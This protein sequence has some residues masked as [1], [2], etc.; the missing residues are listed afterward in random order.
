MAVLTY[1]QMEG[2][3]AKAGFPA[4]VVPIVAAIGE[5]ESGGN[6]DAVNPDDN[7]GTQSSYGW[8]QISTGT[9]TPPSPNWADPATNAALGYQ[10]Y[11]DAGNTF[12]PWGTY[13]SGA[14]KAYL[15]GSTTPD[16]NVS[17]SPTALTAE[18]AAADNVDCMIG[19]SG[20]AGTSWINDLFGSGGNVGNFCLF[21]KSQG[22]GVVGALIMTGGV[23]GFSAALA[24]MMY[25][26]GQRTQIGSAAI[27][28][29]NREAGAEY[30]AGQAVTQASGPGV[31]A[32]G[33]P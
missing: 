25:V 32:A 29:V 33:R 8:L 5:A 2:Y 19:F 20:V 23:A 9:H 31:P 26:A 27:G 13:D 1:A 12:S 16:L 4:A 22:R 7:N 18:T 15:N 6:T 30:D 10:K 14:Y 11:K 21:S 28:L 24:L 3:A 17:G